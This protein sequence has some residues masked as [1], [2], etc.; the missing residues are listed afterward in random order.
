[1]LHLQLIAVPAAV[2]AVATA[3][4]QQPAEPAAVVPS[5]PG[6]QSAFESYEAYKEQPTGSWVESNGTVRRIGGWRAYAN[7][8]QGKAAPATVPSSAPAAPGPHQG[9]RR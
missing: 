3:A 5:V 1:M 2:L 7:E 8:A 9:Q 6:Y 4:A